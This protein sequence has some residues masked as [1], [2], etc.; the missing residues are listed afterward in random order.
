MTPAL[1]RWIPLLGGAL[2]AWAVSAW[3]PPRWGQAWLDLQLEWAAP[4]AVPSGVV[5]VDLDDDAL[6]RL[7]PHV[8]PWPFSRDSHA[9]LIEVLREAGVR[10]IALDILMPEVREGDLA[11]AR[12]LARPGAPVVLPAQG[13]A[14]PAAAPQPGPA[15]RWERIQGP[16]PS[17]QAEGAPPLRAGMVSTPLDSDGVLRHWWLQHRAPEGEWPSL[18]LALHQAL[19][20]STPALAT[21]TQVTPVLARGAVPVLSYADLVLQARNGPLDPSLAAALRDRVVVVGASA[22][23]T[24][25]VMTPW[26]QTLGSEALAKAWVAMRDGQWLQPAPTWA[27]AASVALALL[28]LLPWP[29]WRTHRGPAS[30]ATV[31]RRQRR[32]WTLGLGTALALALALSLPGLALGAGWWWDPSAA[33]AGLAT[34]LMLLAAARQQAARRAAERWQLEQQWAD[35]ADRQRAMH[36]AQVGQALRGPMVALQGLGDLL[37]Q[38]PLDADAARQV[39]LRGRTSRELLRLVDEMLDLSQLELRGLQ[40]DPRPTD[41]PELL[42]EAVAQA[43]SRGVAHQVHC[44]AQLD[45]DLPHWVSV[46]GPRL[47]Q[48]L[49]KLLD[50]AIAH[51][52]LGTVRLDGNLQPDGRVAFTVSDTGLG[53]HPQRLPLRLIALSGPGDA[54]GDASESLGL[55][56]ARELVQ[57]MGGEL[58]LQTLPG[59]G[60]RLRFSLA[61][62]ACEPP[63]T[64]AAP[65]WVAPAGRRL[66]LAE[67]DAVHAELR[68]A[69]GSAMGHEVVAVANGYLATAQAVRQPFDLV[70]LDLQL[71]GP[72]TASIVQAIRDHEAQQGLPPC[73]IALASAQAERLQATDL[74]AVQGRLVLPANGLRW[75]ALLQACW[76]P[77]TT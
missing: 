14:K 37:A 28:P 56:L 12:A 35:E 29:L 17:L 51:A 20:T 73:P 60:S 25:F 9:L 1:S 31:R 74:P 46:D 43:R 26:G 70:V 6:S 27:T 41:L 61:L 11:L 5:V 42:R 69:L 72:D 75:Q 59:M 53:L 57:R 48:V 62:A 22:L 2:V 30:T 49:R 36:L 77:P 8:G 7:R 45:P 3:A 54:D 38:G 52:P 44:D 65:D 66:L 16:S 50:H 71:P 23:G 33:L 34:G 19:G 39:A 18:P 40:L 24:D 15:Y 67:H 64:P 4:D 63:A 21:A 47:A 76:A 68:R 58:D 13:N 10:A 55:R 32:T